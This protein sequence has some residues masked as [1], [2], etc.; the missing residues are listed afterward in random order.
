M[1]C[2]KCGT[3]N[4]N[5]AQ[6]CESCSFGLTSQN[7]QQ[8][9]QK[10]YRIIRSVCPVILVGL[11]A[12]LTIFVKPTSAFIAAAF[13]LYSTIASIREFARRESKKKVRRTTIAIAI[14]VL[15]LSSLMMLILN[16]LRFD[17]PP[18]GNDYTIKDIRS[19]APEYNETYNLLY[20]LVDENKNVK[21]A[22]AIGLSVEE[23]GKIEEI[24]D[25]L[26]DSDLQT[27]SQR[28]DENEEDILLIWENDKERKR[29]FSQTR[30]IS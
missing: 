1:C 24:N 18:I 14:A 12:F 28:L 22:P 29:H 20:S 25:F 3:Q 2:S 8:S 10:T 6:I 19:A 15:M 4:P 30:F 7:T 27:I 17:A 5:D 26:K 21:G 16:Y 9:K 11:A 13:A 23:I